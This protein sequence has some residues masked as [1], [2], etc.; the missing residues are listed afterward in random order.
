DRVR[1]RTG[2]ALTGVGPGTGVRIVAGGTVGLRGF[3]A[4]AAARIADTGHVALIARRAHHRVG[5]H[6]PPALTGVA[7][8]APVGIVAHNAVLLGR[9]RAEA[10]GV[11]AGAG[12]VAL[13]GR[14]ARDGVATHAGPGLTDVAAGA[15][16][17][18]GAGGA[19]RLGVGLAAARALVANAVVALVG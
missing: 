11:I 18:V 3:G 10:G 4:D 12:R 6:A 1:S 2:A 8:R 16:V 15:G 9:V 5:A 19:V 17:A 14:A 7:L 13:I